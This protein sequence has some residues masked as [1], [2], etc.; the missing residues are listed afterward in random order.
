MIK[1]DDSTHTLMR[2]Y[3]T[4]HKMGSFIGRAGTQLLAMSSVKKGPEI[5]DTRTPAI[6]A[7]GLAAKPTLFRALSKTT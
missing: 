6:S 1:K 3:E 5:S 7:Q 4:I 2:V